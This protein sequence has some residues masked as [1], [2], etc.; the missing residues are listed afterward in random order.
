MGF[1]YALNPAIDAVVTVAEPE[2]LLYVPEP[3]GSMRLV[4]VEY[5]V[6]AETWDEGHDGPPSIEGQAFDDH[7]AEE[8]RHGIPFP[9]YD[10]HVWVWEDN[11]NGLFAPFNPGLS[12]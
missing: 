6:M 9:H 5:M 12:C 2:M 1:H 8:A 11:A 4:G 7:R 3:D 10:L